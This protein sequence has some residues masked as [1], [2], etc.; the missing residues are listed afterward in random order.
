MEDLRD[1]ELSGYE[2]N[3]AKVISQKIDSPKTDFIIDLHTTCANMGVSI[4][5]VNDN[6]YNFK[7]AAY[8][9]SKIPN[10]N[11][12]YIPVETYA[13]HNFLNTLSPYGFALEVGPIP[14]GVV[15]HDIFN[16]TSNTIDVALE[17]INMTNSGMLGVIKGIVR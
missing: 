13:E 9:K 6:I 12:Y 4:I 17:F 1:F 10:C 11:I 7:M 15:R 5:L 14:N 2:A 16:Q 8:I 3:R